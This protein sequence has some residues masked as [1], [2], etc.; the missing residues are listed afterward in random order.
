MKT[1][2]D[3]QESG[4][5]EVRRCRNNPGRRESSPLGDL[6]IG[7]YW[8]LWLCLLA[9]QNPHLVAAI[10]LL[11][12]YA[13]EVLRH[14]SLLPKQATGILEF[15]ERLLFF[16][17]AV[18]ETGG[19]EEFRREFAIRLPVLCYHH[20]GTK[21]SGSWPIL[22][23]STDVF[24]RQILWLA[25]QGY[26]GI[27]ANDW[28]DWVRC[29]KLLPEKPI[30]ITFDDGYSDLLQ[31][32]FPVLKASNYKS[33]MFVVSQYIGGPGDWPSPLGYTGRPL[34]TAEQILE[35]ARDGVE[36][37]AHSRTH[38][39]LRNLSPDELKTELTLCRVELSD[40]VGGPVNTLAYPFGYHNLQVRDCASQIYDIA[41]SSTPGLNVWRS[42]RS[43]L[44]RMFVNRS[45][46]NFFLQVKFGLDFCA[47]F[48]FL[49]NRTG[50]WISSVFTGVPKTAQHSPLSSWKLE[51]QS[52]ALPHRGV[53]EG[54]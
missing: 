22:T 3:C 44:R 42:D 15:R 39:D 6:T 31:N 46:I 43:Q 23:V 24:T 50:R 30:L 10:L 29:G 18:A 4:R 16:S 1:I 52:S 12:G 38:R 26:T 53:P 25:E 35:L 19:W 41:F 14:F 48:R 11:P 2:E 8:R 33:T 28:L 34:M 49:K 45:R 37:G 9:W 40:L 21:L 47:A 13:A 5:E 7:G 20:V 36:I 32:A 51:Q 27:H 17:G 54:R